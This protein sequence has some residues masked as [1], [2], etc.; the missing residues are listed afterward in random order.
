[1]EMITSKEEYFTELL[2]SLDLKDFITE[3][4]LE[5]VFETGIINKHKSDSRKIRAKERYE[6]F[7]PWQKEAFKYFFN[8]HDIEPS[9][10]NFGYDLSFIN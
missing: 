1:M 10:N 5:E 3:T 9:Y 4:Y 2:N 8:L 6:Y 7:L